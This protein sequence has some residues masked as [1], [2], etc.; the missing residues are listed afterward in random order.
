[1]KTAFTTFLF[2]VLTTVRTLQREMHTV[3]VL[4]RHHVA[5][6]RS[7]LQLRGPV[8][9]LTNVDTTQQIQA[10]DTNRKYEYWLRPSRV[11]LEPISAA[12]GTLFWWRHAHMTFLETERHSETS[13]PTDKNIGP[14]NRNDMRMYTIS[15]HSGENS[16]TYVNA[17]HR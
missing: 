13:T 11:A 8:N 12:S 3:C 17:L 14:H 16:K 15:L 2:P 1:V 10:N 7:C 9:L 4:Q 6:I 5:F